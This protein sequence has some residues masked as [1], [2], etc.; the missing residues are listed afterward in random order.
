MFA[1]NQF[2]CMYTC[3]YVNR[4]LLLLSALVISYYVFVGLKPL[5]Q[6]VF[7]SYFF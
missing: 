4:V 7:H 2:V 3:S 5:L 1:L 6:N